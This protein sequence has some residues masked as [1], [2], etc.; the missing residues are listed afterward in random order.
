[1][2]GFWVWSLVSIGCGGSAVDTDG[3]AELAARGLEG[4]VQRA[5]LLGLDGFA[6]ASSANIPQQAGSGDL[7]GTM[8]VDGQVDQGASDNKG[9]RLDVVMV[10]YADLETVVGVEGD[11]VAVVYDTLSDDALRME[12]SLRDIPTGTLMGS[13]AGELAMTGD[14]EGTVTLDLTLDGTL[15]PRPDDPDTPRSVDGSTSV[16]GTATNSGGGTYTVDIVL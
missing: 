10:D 4:A 14:L 9:L 12:L 1:M 13:L 2:R 11:V 15:E 8:T 7:Q 3:E 5:L 6:A 16:T